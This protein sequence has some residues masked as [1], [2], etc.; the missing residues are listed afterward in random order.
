MHVRGPGAQLGI[1][2]TNVQALGGP[3]PTTV[4]AAVDD[5]VKRGLA[6][7]LGPDITI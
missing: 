4:C 3:E 1:G 6:R 2:D 5:E 7:L